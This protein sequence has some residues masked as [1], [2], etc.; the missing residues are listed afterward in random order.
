MTTRSLGGRGPGPSAR[1]GVAAG[2]RALPPRSS[3]APAR[4]L[5]P[6]LPA[7]PSPAGDG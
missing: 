3:R 6:A 1:R 5:D 4:T 7:L 2:P